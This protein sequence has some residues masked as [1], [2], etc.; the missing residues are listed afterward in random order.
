MG[1]SVLYNPID[2]STSQLAQGVY[3]ATR[4]GKVAKKVVS[5][6]DTI[7]TD[8]EDE[9]SYGYIYINSI[10]EKA[11]DFSYIEYSKD[12]THHTEKS[13]LLGINQTIDLNGDGFANLSY[14]KP[15]TKR[16]GFEKTL[17][18][19][20]ISN[21]DEQYTSMFSVLP[22]QYTRGVYPAGLYGINPDGHFIV[23][24]Y[25]NNSS[26]RSVVKGL[27]SGDFV[28]DNATGTYHK[29]KGNV[30]YKNARNIDEADLETEDAIT[31]VNFYFTEEDFSTGYSAISLLA[32]LPL[33][34]TNSY[35]SIY[36][37]NE[38]IEVL[39]K[40][41]L[42]E[43]FICFCIQNLNLDIDSEIQEILDIA[44]T[45][46]EYELVSLN[47]MFMSDTFKEECPAIDYK[48]TDITDIL[49]LVSVYI[50]AS[51]IKTEAD[52]SETRSIAVSDF[53]PIALPTVTN[54]DD[55]R[56]RSE[57]ADWQNIEFSGKSGY[58]LATSYNEY[59]MNAN[60]LHEKVSNCKKLNIG[61][62]SK[63]ITNNNLGLGN[64]DSGNLTFADIDIKTDLYIGGHFTIS[65]SNCNADLSAYT[66]LSAYAKTCLK[67]AYSGSLIGGE[68]N[69]FN[70]N[71]S[72][73]MGPIPFIYGLKGDYDVPFAI[74]GE[75]ESE[76]LYS[77]FTGLAGTTVNVGADY[78][79]R[80]VKW[81]KIW[82]KWIYRPSIYFEPY[83]KTCDSLAECAF[84]AGIAD[85][86][87]EN[88]FSLT[89]VVSPYFVL[90]PYLGLGVSTGNININFP[91]TEQVSTGIDIKSNGSIEGFFSNEFSIQFGGS[92]DLTLPIVGHKS[93]NFGRID[94]YRTLQKTNNFSIN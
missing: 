17:W 6:D 28:L 47:R 82:R 29:V 78:G 37:E 42:R 59:I 85:S 80:M 56:I 92:F 33:N 67:Y 40:I 73:C 36:S 94:I 25:E 70:V 65:W 66:M 46:S 35:G 48:C 71:G 15:M 54:I 58:K 84:F 61:F 81:F 4:L 32:T 63:K 62:L 83:T 69:I 90:T 8:I 26:T 27:A 51:E 87:K 64:S 23:S 50:D 75:M 55:F 13:F 79:T 18:L 10:S 22:E 12:G 41:L 86:S 74:N 52:T 19:T 91:V 31:D 89:A 76:F 68:Q 5:D 20:F 24:K 16:S 2:L 7:Y 57:L 3:V 72:F 93:K 11:L 60:K 88:V 77:G 1:G 49:P 21:Q 34:I 44:S 38:A 53:A 43:D 45:L 39:N 14:S 9:A 30:S